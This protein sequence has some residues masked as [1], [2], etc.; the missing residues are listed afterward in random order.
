MAWRDNPALAGALIGLAIGWVKYMLALGMIGAAVGREAKRAPDQ[1]DFA[2]FGAR[3][4]PVKRTLL[5]VA[6]GVLPAIG[7]IA[8]AALGK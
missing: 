3:L 6:F 8:G 5:V 2:G 1:V 7:F 4:R